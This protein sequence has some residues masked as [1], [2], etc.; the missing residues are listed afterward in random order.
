MRDLI[1]AETLVVVGILSGVL[2]VGSL[3]ATPI[4]LVRMP[5]N[6]FDENRSRSW[7]RT[8]NVVLR[9]I[10]RVFKNLTGIV[11]VLAGGAMIVLPGPGL[12][13]ILFGLS[14]L[15]FP[16]TNNLER[17]IFARPAILRTINSVRAKFGK[18][19]LAI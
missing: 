14:L 15:D 10:V 12:L 2:F 9:I 17:R 3:I 19:P 18:P 1:S 8:N 4:L 5:V 11:L 13:S 7:F 6:Y 16:G